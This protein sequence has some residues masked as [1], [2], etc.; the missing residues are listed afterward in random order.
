MYVCVF[1]ENKKEENALKLGTILK[2]ILYSVVL[3]IYGNL[4]YTFQVDFS[5]KETVSR[6]LMVCGSGLYKPWSLHL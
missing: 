4:I 2:P 6:T 3:A 5:K 1:I